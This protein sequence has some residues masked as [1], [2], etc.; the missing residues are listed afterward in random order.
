M[1]GICAEKQS[2]NEKRDQ[3]NTFNG[4]RMIN[5]LIDFINTFN[6]KNRDIY[7]RLAQLYHSQITLNLVTYVLL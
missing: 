3:V 7:T 5:R 2:K 6:T 4:G 1:T